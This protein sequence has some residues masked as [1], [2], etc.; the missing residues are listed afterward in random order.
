MDIVTLGARCR[1][2]GDNRRD[3][4]AS[5]VVTDHAVARVL[6]GVGAKA[7]ARKTVRKLP[8][9]MAV[10]DHA[11]L[12]IERDELV[13]D[14]GALAMAAPTGGRARPIEAAL[15]IVAVTGTASEAQSSD[16]G[17]VSGTVLVDDPA[18]VHVGLGP[19]WSRGAAQLEHELNARQRGSDQH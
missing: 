2:V 5:R 15:T 3:L 14:V 18:R 4:A 13:V 1:V 7:M 11:V 17:L 10:L 16:V 8:L 6:G 9:A 19:R 12:T